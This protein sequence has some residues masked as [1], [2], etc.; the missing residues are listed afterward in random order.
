MFTTVATGKNLTYRWA[1]AIPPAGFL[2]L[3]D[4]GNISGALTP[5]LSISNITGPVNATYR[6]RVF[7]T[8]GNVD[9]TL[10]NIIYCP[11][12]F[13]CDGLITIADIFSFLSAWFAGNP[14]ADFNSA[15]GIGVADIFDFLS[16]WFAGC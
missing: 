11:A 13:N 12:D 8:C 10:V 6:C 1:R 3:S 16:A 5:T 2:N 14:A 7:S 15:G 9:A 4:G